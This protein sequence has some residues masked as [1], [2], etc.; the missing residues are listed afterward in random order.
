[1]INFIRHGEK[2]YNDTNDTHLS[3]DGF[4][5]AT[6]IERCVGAPGATLAFPN[7][8]PTKLLAGSRTDNVTGAAISVRPSETIQPLANKLG[9]PIKADIDMADLVGFAQYVQQNLTAGETWFVSWQHWFIP[10][11]AKQFDPNGLAEP[12]FPFPKHCNYTEWTEPDYIKGKCYDLMVQLVLERDNS[13]RPWR[14]Q[15]WADMHMG[16]GGK[17]SSPCESAFKPHSNPTS[18]KWA[19]KY[20]WTDAPPSLPPTLAE[21]TPINGMKEQVLEVLC[22]VLTIL[23]VV[24]L[25][26]RKSANTQGPAASYKEHLLASA[27][28]NENKGYRNGRHGLTI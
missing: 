13:S 6:Y 8:H 20:G 3:I 23:L 10:L 18:W 1:M 21:T 14:I 4:H 15:A 28:A 7:G 9:L 11:I 27:N 19:M 25:V 16:F 22:A 12:H 2:F 26:T 24:S 17:A 5:R